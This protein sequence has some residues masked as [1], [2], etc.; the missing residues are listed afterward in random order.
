M[1]Y[2]GFFVLIILFFASFPAAAAE[3]LP[4]CICSEKSFG[5]RWHQAEAVFAGTVTG[6]EIQERNVRKGIDDPPVRVT[7]R[8]DERYK[9]VKD[10][11]EA[12]DLH[13]SLS[14]FTCTGH[15]F[16]LGKQYLVFGYERVD[17][18]YV[19]EDLYRYEKGTFDV[20]GLCGGTKLFSA[21][22]DDLSAITD[23]MR[24]EGAEKKKF[25]FF[26]KN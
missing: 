15:P 17:Y 7:L 2:I 25:K 9:G 5:A 24:E 22:Q 20:G 10:N 21:A 12:F 26:N 13:T 6:I 8:V 16:E 14:R 19:Q 11:K 3:E 4:R 1:K 18:A 23:L